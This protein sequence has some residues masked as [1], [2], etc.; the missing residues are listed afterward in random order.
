MITF[1]NRCRA[2]TATSVAFYCRME[3]LIL[4]TVVKSG[5]RMTYHITNFRNVLHHVLVKAP[6][7]RKM[8]QGVKGAYRHIQYM[9]IHWNC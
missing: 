5:E 2:F 6:Q 9:Y 8:V 4:N 7:F 3:P 1:S